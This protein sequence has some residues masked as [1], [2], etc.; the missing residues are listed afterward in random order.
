MKIVIA[1]VPYFERT[2][3]QAFDIYTC[4]KVSDMMI[5]ISSSLPSPYPSDTNLPV[6]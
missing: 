5:S 6:D 1:I 2:T 3:F 4:E